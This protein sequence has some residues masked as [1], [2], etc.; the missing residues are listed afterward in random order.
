MADI[1]SL[2]GKRVWVAGHTGLVGS[3]LVRRLG[4]ERCDILQVG[5]AELD[6]RRQTD[7]QGWMDRQKPEVIIIAAAKVGGIGANH[8]FPADFISDNLAIAQN[9]ID[10]AAR[11]RVEKLV[12]LGSSCIYPK[13]APQPIPETALMTGSLEPTNEAYAIAKIAG[14]KLC[15]FYRRQHGHDFISLMPCNL[16]GPG[17]RWQDA[18]AHVIPALIKRFH[19]AKAAGLPSVTIWGS[20][21]P[22]RE[23][24]YV[25]DLAD[26][27]VHL[28]KVYSDEL[29]INVGSGAEISIGELARQIANVCGYEGE[30]V[31]DRT[32]PDGTPRKLMDTT[33]LRAT[34]WAPQTSLEAGLKLAYADFLQASSV[35]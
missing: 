23:F 7:V 24:L 18:G 12:F 13:F 11:Q 17:D 10:Q 35:L 14:L 9:I 30:I 29:H 15:Q 2:A 8:E 5:R 3:V 20:G 32:K 25:D 4:R 31:F 22:L 21:T 1:F 33:R 26:A 16:Y 6:L 27:C 34:G 28:L 19:E